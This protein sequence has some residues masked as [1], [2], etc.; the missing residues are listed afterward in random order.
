M[1][2]LRLHCSG[3]AVCEFLHQEEHSDQ[4]ARSDEDGLSGGGAKPVRE[5]AGSRE[6]EGQ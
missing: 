6:Q 3:W 1:D 4:N 5:K 2:L